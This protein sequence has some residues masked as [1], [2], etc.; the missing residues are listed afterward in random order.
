MFQVAVTSRDIATSTDNVTTETGT[1]VV[2]I[3]TCEAQT[4][5][6]NDNEQPGNV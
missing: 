6:S 5:T 1:Q 2:S 4:Q 3:L